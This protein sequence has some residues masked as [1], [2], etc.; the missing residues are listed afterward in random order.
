MESFATRLKELRAVTQ[1]TQKKLS[2]FLGLTP[3]CICEWENNRSEPSIISLTKIASYF[4]VSVDYLL[5]LEDDFGAPTAAAMGERSGYSS[6][7][8]KLVEEYR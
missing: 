8:R 1:C 5:G 3:N 6:E 4:E 7:E 2:T